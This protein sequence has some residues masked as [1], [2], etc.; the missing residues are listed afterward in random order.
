M[1][2]L[3]N[4]CFLKIFNNLQRDNGDL[5]HKDLFSCLLVNRQ[6]CRIIVPILWSNPLIHFS[7]KKLIR[8]C[9]LTLNSEEQ[10][11]LIPFKITLPNDPKP[12]FNYTSYITFV[13]NYLNSGI[14]DWL[15]NERCETDNDWR[16]NQNRSYQPSYGSNRHLM[17]Y[18]YEGLVNA[19]KCSLIKMFLRTSKNL[20]NLIINGIIHDKMILEDIYRKTT[21]TTIKFSYSSFNS[22]ERKLFMEILNRNITL[23][24]LSFENCKLGSEGGQVLAEK[25]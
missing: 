7:N 22:E 15:Y 23:T 20:D 9:L 2:A 13:S 11:L 12:L 3:P 17:I 21:I 25:E 18:Y 4:E 24:S 10:T 16:S 5:L 19:I 14:D 6:W 8:I 1:I